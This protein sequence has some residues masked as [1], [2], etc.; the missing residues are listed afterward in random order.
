LQAIVK[1]DKADELQSTEKET[2]R[3]QSQASIKSGKLEENLQ[4]VEEKLSRPASQASIKSDKLEIGTERKE[5]IVSQ[6][7]DD[8][9]EVAKDSS[10]PLSQASDKSDVKLDVHLETDKETSRPHSQTS[11]KSVQSETEKVDTEEK[12]SEKELSRPASQA[13]IKSDKDSKLDE[14]RRESVISQSSLVETKEAFAEIVIEEKVQTVEDRKDSVTLQ[15][16]HSPRPQSQA[17]VKSHKSEELND[18]ATEKENQEKLHDEKELRSQSR[19]SIKSDI[20]EKDHIKEEIILEQTS[21]IVSQTMQ[22]S[23]QENTT[24]EKCVEKITLVQEECARPASQASVKS[25]KSDKLAEMESKTELSRPESQASGQKT[26]ENELIIHEE[27]GSPIDV[28]DDKLNDFKEPSRPDSPLSFNEDDLD[29]KIEV[30]KKQSISQTDIA[31]VEKMSELVKTSEMPG[32]PIELAETKMEAFEPHSRPESPSS[33]KSENDGLANEEKID[34][35]KDRLSRPASQASVKSDKLEPIEKVN[36]VIDDLERRESHASVKSEKSVGKLEDHEISPEK[37]KETPRPAS[38][39]SDKLAPIEKENKV[40]EDLQRPES[41]ASAKSDKSAGKLDDHEKLLTQKDASRSA[42]Q[43][44]I[45][46]DKLEPIEMEEVEEIPCRESIISQTTE[47]LEKEKDSSRPQSQASVK[48]EKSVKEEIHE[49]I[50]RASILSQSSHISEKLD[51]HKDIN[52]MA[53]IPSKE[54]SRPTSQASVKSDKSIERESS[55]VIEKIVSI[56]SHVEEKVQETLVSQTSEMKSETQSDSPRPGSQASEKSDKLLDPQKEV[57]RP[58]SQ[59]S[60]KSDKICAGEKETSRPE[61]QASLQGDKHEE[62]TI[63]S[64]IDI[65]EEIS[66][67]KE[68]SEEKS[69]SN[70]S[71]VSQQISE[72]VETHVTESSEKCKEIIQTTSTTTEKTIQECKES[73]VT[74]MSETTES[75]KSSK[76][77]S[78]HIILKS[79]T[80]RNETLSQA[81]RIFDSR[82]ESATSQ[83]TEV[84]DSRR[85]STISEKSETSDSRRGSDM[86]FPVSRDDFDSFRIEDDKVYMKE[87]RSKSV[88]S[89]SSMSGRTDDFGKLTAIDEVLATSRD[90][91]HFLSKA[92]EENYSFKVSS[93]KFR[94]SEDQSE[95]ISTVTTHFPITSESISSST[96]SGFPVQFR[97]ISSEATI[98][99]DTKKSEF[100]EITSKIIETTE[101]STV[102]KETIQTTN[103]VEITTDMS[104]QEEKCEG[105][106]TPPTVP[107]S[108][109]IVTES[110]AQKEATQLFECTSVKSSEVTTER[111]HLSG[112]S[113]PKESIHSGKSSPDSHASKSTAL[114]H[115]SVAETPESSPKPTSPFPKTIESLKHADEHKISSGIS[116]PEMTRTS[117]P[118]T[119]EKFIDNKASRPGEIKTDTFEKTIEFTSSMVIGSYG[120]EKDGYDHEFDPQN[121]QY[122]S[123]WCSGEYHDDDIPLSEDEIPPR[124]DSEEVKSAISI[125]SYKSDPMSTSF[126]GTLPEPITTTTTMVTS[127][128]AKSVPIPITATKTITRTYVEY[129]SSPESSSVESSKKYTKYLDEADLDFEKTFHEPLVKSSTVVTTTTTKT[130]ENIQLDPA[131]K[132]ETVS[133]TVTTVTTQDSSTEGASSLLAQQAATTTT[134]T[135]TEEIQKPWDK[136]LSLPS[137]APT[138]SDSEMKTTPKRERKL[139][140]AKNKINNEK[141]LRKRSESPMAAKKLNPVYIDLAY[142]PHHG[143]SY[144]S[145]VEFFKK[146]RARYYVFSGL[147]PSREVYNALLEAKQTWEDKTLG[148][149]QIDILI[150]YLANIFYFSYDHRSHHNSNI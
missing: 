137:P 67:L 146:V 25:E 21:H 123:K 135:K 150:S 13:S 50:R 130:I 54:G 57:S 148:K 55:Q 35:P 43:A 72:K 87:S 109:N 82:R 141:N 108:P 3:P 38:Q 32:S 136:P 34:S 31:S 142:V 147:E 119:T 88:S 26:P 127:D 131:Q 112:K 77:L 60:E 68:I 1:S 115:G 81:E 94:T 113:S 92:S 47:F 86:K 85:E 74:A 19:S 79:D 144:Y 45:K 48:S 5:S 24:I 69:E 10:R 12:K 42:S 76:L 100:S 133:S 91:L 129:T 6:K 140:L 93:D 106:K 90:D 65:S 73:V 149:C 139:M 125:S 66:H 56:T 110:K 107:V 44:S 105:K 39:A 41:Q 28:A 8:K 97:D 4:E 9:L 2:S 64:K 29:G 128:N 111:V 17:S 11:I 52:E 40:I 80:V 102:S 51:D 83:K 145:H 71:Q 101:S 63:E 96:D 53:K 99:M 89:V 117:T 58:Q 114:G 124:Y 104:E 143:N 84:L 134:T 16:D 61:S 70:I 46:S 132:G 18:A 75:L 122:V 98:S 120:Y 62:K 59:A 126:Y 37:E 49:D 30:K 36:K 20:S 103:L 7:D 27:A 23:Q 118:D 95:D 138:P 78:D 33:C 14:I 15:A 121:S 116:S 22:S